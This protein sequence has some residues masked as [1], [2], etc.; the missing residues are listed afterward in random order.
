VTTRLIHRPART[1]RHRAEGEPLRIEAP[2]T[3]PEGKAGSGVM[4]L[5]P[6]MGVMGSVVMMTVL[7]S[8]GSFAV[9]GAL[10]LVG[11]VIGSAVLLLSQRGQ[12]ARRR[13]QHRERY[14]EYLEDL[15]DRLGGEEREAQTWARVINPA[16]QA[17]YDV[18]RDPSRLWERRRGDPDFLTVRVGVGEV[19]GRAM[20]IQE[21]GSVISPTDRFMLAEAR[22][23][24][25]RFEA[26]PQMPLT[27]PLDRAGN[28][29]VV[30][31]RTA[32]LRA[33][34]ALLMQVTALHAPDDVALA[35]SYDP[36]A[37][38][39]W[40]WM[41]WL[42][43]VLDPEQRDGPVRARRMATDIAELAAIMSADLTE[44]AAHAA[45]VRRGLGRD[46]LPAGPRMLV[47]HDAY[48]GVARELRRPDESV[49]L[50]DMGVTVLHLI[51]DRVLEPGDVTVRLT[52]DGDRVTVEDLRGDEP[53]VSSGV[54]DDV[55]P[56]TAEG[57][58]RMVAPLRMSADSVEAAAA[59][60]GADF[61]GLLGIDDPARLNL[62]RAW[63]PRGEREFL[64]VPLGVDDTGRPVH[65]DLK[66][67]AQLGMGPH[68]LCV[69]ATGSGKS[70]L[71]RTL[72]LSLLL[73]HSPDQLGM[74]LVDYK[75][76]ATFAPFDGLP[77]VAGIITNLEDDAGLIERAYASLAGEVQRRQQ[78]LKNAGNVAN[79]ADYRALRERRP[80]LPALPHLLVIIDEFGE[81][82]T[83]RPDFIELFLSIGRI[84]RSIGVHLLLSS[85]RIEAGKLRG[86]ETYLSYRLGLRTFSEDESRT[87]LDSADAF[88]LPPLPGFGYLKVDT[89]VYTRFK[90]AYVSGPYR[91]PAAPRD[92]DEEERFG[93]LPYPALNTLAA[94][95]PGGEEAE[96][97]LPKRAAGPTLLDVVVGRLRDAERVR[98]IWLPPLPD[99]VTLD[100][101]AGPVDVTGE[102]MRLAGGPPS[103]MRAPI[104]LLDDPARQRQDV[105]TLDLT[106]A[107]GHVAVI[108]APQS[109]KTNLLRT[110]VTALALT[111]TPRQVAVYALDLVGG[112]LQPLAR[113]PHVGGVARRVDRERVRRTVEEVRGM[114][115]DREEVFRARGIDSVERLRQMHAAGQVPELATPDVVL[116]IDGFGGI[117]EDFEE[118]DEAVSDLLQRGG[119]FGIHVVAAMLRWN[120]VRMAIQGTFGT[121]LEL[122]LNDPTD[123][124]VARRL[125]ETIRPDQP[126]RVLTDSG[127]FAQ[128]ALARIDGA[129][130]ASGLGE[131]TEQT[132][133][134][135]R[136]AWPGDPVPQ[137]RVLPS[138]L[139]RD[140]LPGVA[141]EPALLPIGV[142]ETAL[143]PVLLDLFERDQN[144]V[145]LGDGECGKTNLLRLVAT[146][147]IERFPS[148]RLVFAVMDPRRGLRDAVPDAYLGGYAS[149]AGV[150]GGL[151]TGI[152]SE[153]EKRLPDET[154]DQKALAEGTWFTGPRIVVL[155]DDYDVLTTA[156]QQ[157]LAP[158]VPYIPSG[159]DIGLHF[160]VARRVA[161]ASRGLYE[162]FL[163]TLRESGTSALVMAGDR[164]EGVL[165]DDVYASPLPP[166]RGRL[167]RRAE[168]PH[169]VQT[170]LA[171]AEGMP[172]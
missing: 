103:Q 101:I 63:A 66:E 14:L 18:I 131:A 104:G 35:A 13:R 144:L 100:A 122:R 121:R 162:P 79:I 115:L 98:Q 45:E 71:L 89:S 34:R 10:L 80:E 31:D 50:P 83:A 30:G 2:P 29:S 99:A 36:P 164:S 93:L 82:L 152:A 170:A 75:G 132:A 69:G 17:L 52:V 76:G 142:N 145:V 108:G 48:G 81:L 4:T 107:G 172:H 64:R 47:V 15:R 8:N 62:D 123:S 41:K 160:V 70:E 143:S 137:V 67:A 57:I 55:G 25:R 147:L 20:R 40:V 92:K 128:A 90:G 138:V 127:S 23:V 148:D 51:S 106:T 114:L 26:M 158:F 84:G 3:L 60:G 11:V 49:P 95:D 125:A 6:V 88:H 169:L 119:G 136:G 166:G 116:L 28:V 117:R 1:T 120:D 19:A 118:L 146:G 9:I 12:A 154:T 150:C 85:Q 126:G 129:P 130:S 77:H 39:D 141:A 73:T 94:P 61:G 124:M 74:V 59:A 16:P 168:R 43:H 165:F 102:G 157:P 149:N 87:V 56:A 42:P 109:G 46:R 134:A 140:E 27:V 156:G 72:V 161:G 65:L 91:G 105:W 167:V 5:L 53:A 78:V 21:Q 68:G 7:R 22:A 139:T 112:G 135:V 159:R 163:M 38:H 44:R 97:V 155:I 37:A 58:A 111:H 133:R 54:L 96:S 151:A 86:L 110:I 32:V 24:T 33:V 113:L 171:T 153:L